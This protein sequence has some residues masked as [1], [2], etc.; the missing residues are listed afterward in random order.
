MDITGKIFLNILRSL[1]KITNLGCEA[2]VRHEQTI[3]VTYIVYLCTFRMEWNTSLLDVTG[4]F[5]ERIFLN[6]IQ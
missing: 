5:K 6:M 3:L 1:H 2:C 4:M